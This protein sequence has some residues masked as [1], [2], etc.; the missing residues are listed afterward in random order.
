MRV[1][2][3]RKLV[4]LPRGIIP[5]MVTPLAERD[6]LDHA[7]TE[8]L[9]EHLIAG[10]V[11]GLF[12]LGTTGEAPSLSYRLR[13]ELVE[14]VGELLAGRVPLLVGIT[15]AALS[16]AVDMAEHACDA[17]ASAVVAAPPYY[18]PISQ[19]ELT[20]HFERLVAELPLPLVLY[21]MPS[22]TKV[23]FE[24]ET[25]VQLSRLPG[26]IGLKDSSGDLDY[27]RRLRALLAGHDNFR[28]F[29]GPEELL[30][31]AM[32]AGADGGVSGGANMFPQLYV[33]LCRAA[34]SEDM[35]RARQLQALV[36]HISSNLYSLGEH[37]SRVINGIK[38]VLAQLGICRSTVAE[39]FGEF[40][41][42]RQQQIARRLRDVQQRLVEVLG[43]GAVCPEAR[44][45]SAEK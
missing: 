11:S 35:T 38:T 29:V 22:C 45:G 21:N 41:S 24:A 19:A 14:R 4:T 6:V 18:Y 42:G 40:D 23:A 1:S 12:V 10:G 37:A 36:L 28:L 5:P 2:A 7:G 34:R 3:H 30:S 33:E 26:V 9:V 17:G 27:F 31:E 16:E 44:V 8:R 39:P 15:D 43:P 32:A 25:V 20:R 13:Y